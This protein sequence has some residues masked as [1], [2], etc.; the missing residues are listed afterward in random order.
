[1][2]LFFG[3]ARFPSHQFQ[4]RQSPNQCRSSKGC[5]TRGTGIRPVVVRVV[6][7]VVVVVATFCIFG[8]HSTTIFRDTFHITFNEIGFRAILFLVTKQS[9]TTFGAID[10]DRLITFDNRPSFGF[11]GNCRT[12][13]SSTAAL[14]IG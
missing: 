4:G 9:K 13:K 12:G 1:M 6:V 5:V 2:I 11:A 14:G 7:V 3:H 8:E 10:T